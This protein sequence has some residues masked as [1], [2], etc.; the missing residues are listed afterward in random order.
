[1]GRRNR[2]RGRDTSRSERSRESLR[3]GAQQIA[4][5]MTT[6]QLIWHGAP[7]RRPYRDLQLRNT[8]HTSPQLASLALD[9]SVAAM[10]L[11]LWA[12]LAGSC[13][14]H[15][16]LSLFSGGGDGGCSGDNG[17]GVNSRRRSTTATATT[18]AVMAFAAAA[19]PPRLL[20]RRE[21]S[22][23]LYSPGAADTTTTAM[24]STRQQQ[25]SRRSSNNMQQQ[26]R[27]RQP[28]PAAAEAAGT[29]RSRLLPLP[30]SPSWRLYAARRAKPDD[31]DDYYDDRGRTDPP[32]TTS[33]RPPVRGNPA[34]S[35]R[36]RGR[37]G[38]GAG[39]GVGGRNNGGES[40]A[41]SAGRG[42]GGR[43][44]GIDQSDPLVRDWNSAKNALAGRGEGG[45]GGGRR[46]ERRYVQD[47]AG[48]AGRG[49]GRGRGRGRGRGYNKT[50]V[51]MYVGSDTV[52]WYIKEVQVRVLGR[53][54]GV[55][56]VQ[57]AHPRDFEFGGGV[58]LSVRTRE[59]ETM[60]GLRSCD[61][62]LA[63][64]WAPWCYF[65]KHAQQGETDVFTYSP[66]TTF[67][68]MRSSGY[69][70]KGFASA[71][72]YLDVLFESLQVA[73]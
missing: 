63:P 69:I 66:E 27:R 46:G 31:D 71:S 70:R 5:G 65:L 45:R 28:A 58:L 13:L 20:A 36:G 41:A 7:S 24:V 17:V 16:G 9:Y 2:E 72:W 57:W 10:H 38:S 50:P 1:M 53:L 23:R 32:T 6:Y 8:A 44:R 19:P 37:P 49:G 35:S 29:P 15:P 62:A 61:V 43:G 25:C 55:R 52:P 22:S 39:R 64:R 34:A 14:L 33:G 73:P 51:G 47:S 3:G 18:A 4:E 42:G 21:S 54:G 59:R 60:E 11:Y 68:G 30:P 67:E 40:P 26:R 56:R 12:S 48:R